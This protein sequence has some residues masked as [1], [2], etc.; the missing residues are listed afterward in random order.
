MNRFFNTLLC[1]GCFVFTLAGAGNTEKKGD[2][3]VQKNRYVQG[4]NILSDDE[5]LAEM[6]IE[7]SREYGINHLQLSH[8]LIMDLRHAK[9]LTRAAR[10]NRLV[11]KAHEAGIP[12]VLIWDHMLYPLNYYPKEFRSGPD[13]LI[14]LDN[15]E[16]W[17]WIKNDYREMLGLV[18]GIDG[19]ILTFIET[20]ARI[21]NQ[22]SRVLKTPQEKLAAMIDTISSL[23]IDEKGLELYVRTFFYTRQE[24]ENMLNC[25]NLI[26]NKGIRVMTKE[27]PH[28]FFLTHPPAS[29]V[30]DI[31]F[32]VII[33]F[34]AAHEYNGQGIIASIF[35]GLHLKRWE[36][37]KKL[38]NVI[39]YV[40]RT[41]RSHN[42]TIL[43]HNPAEINLAVLHEA[44][45]NEVDID[46]VYHRFV[47][48]KYGKA[49]VPFLVPAMKK[50]Y[51]VVSSVFYT[52]GLNTNSHSRLQYDDNSAYQRHVSGKWM[53][54]PVVR[55]E[56]GVNKEF[57]YWQ[58]IVNHLAPAW[59]K[60]D[61]KTQL[62]KESQWVLEQG[63]L[64]P[65]EKINEEYLRYV[66]TEKKFGVEQA[67]LALQLVRQAEQHVTG[68]NSYDSLLH[69][70]ER[71][72]LTARLYEASAKVFFGFR[73]YARGDRFQTEFVTRKLSEG[74]A[75]LKEVAL[76][77]YRYPFKGPVGQF[78]WEED[79]YRGLA[80]YNAIQNRQSDDFTP[81][82]FPYFPYEGIPPKEREKIWDEAFKGNK[83]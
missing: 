5:K 46:S 26:Q 82:T 29:Y 83:R 52:L 77:M 8:H 4:W 59:Y 22:H 38:P 11:D 17:A 51:D 70:F 73:V 14:D 10:V 56:N 54:N 60:R 75:D 48:K 41:D 76:E 21:E 25:L 16:F 71:T 28:D 64:Q 81:N 43:N 49:A 69:I 6:V 68:T 2:R 12:K 39:G 1:L 18:P 37:Y 13:S 57:H 24:R 58:D 42:S 19:L 36:S 63:W 15:P 3:E 30:G 27:V 31:K 7:R 78:E 35:P 33:E 74:L 44:F 32:P 79:I 50:S 23:I 80:Y 34:D 62:A 55:I 72:L 40:A 53:D 67:S 9:N 66:L 20:G 47:T 45:N 65:M 61:E